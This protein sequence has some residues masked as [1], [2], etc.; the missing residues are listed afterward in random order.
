MPTSPLHM[1]VCGYDI[2]HEAT[3]LSTSVPGPQVDNEGRRE[4]GRKGNKEATSQTEHLG[5]NMPCPHP[6]QCSSTWRAELR[7]PK[8]TTHQDKCTGPH[9]HYFAQFNETHGV[10]RR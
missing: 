10:S 9:R 3:I 6:A 7:D 5:P 4:D 8:R 1:A 2:H